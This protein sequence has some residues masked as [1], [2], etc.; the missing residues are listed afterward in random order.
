MK[1]IEEVALEIS[2]EYALEMQKN[3]IR[4]SPFDL[5]LIFRKGAEYALSTAWK[6]AQGDELP[7]TDREVIALTSHAG[8]SFKVVYAHRPNKNGWDGRNIDT[9]EVE[10]YTPCVYDKGEWNMPDVKFWLDI[11]LPYENKPK[12]K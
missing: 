3:G 9:G 8:R 12:G 11:S 1:K 7:E 5:D 2:N 10:H 6:D 4:L